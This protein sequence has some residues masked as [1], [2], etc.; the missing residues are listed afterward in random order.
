[1]LYK[2]KHEK[3]LQSYLKDLIV[4]KFIFLRNHLGDWPSGAVAKF[5]CSALAAQ[6]VLVL[7]LGVDLHTT[8]QAM[9]WQH[10]TYKIEEDW[11]RC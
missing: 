2:T 10:L 9:L 8:H 7:I 6:G 5:V 1:M 11:H 3:I 4:I